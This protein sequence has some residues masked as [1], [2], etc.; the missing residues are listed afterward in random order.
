M[1]IAEWNDQDGAFQYK[2]FDSELDAYEFAHDA[3]LDCLVSVS[4]RPYYFKTREME[5]EYQ[6]FIAE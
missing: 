2:M 3:Y 5:I 1:F 6:H 4:V